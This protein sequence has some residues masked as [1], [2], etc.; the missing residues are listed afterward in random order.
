ME[1]TS[2]FALYDDI[3]VDE[4]CPA[5]FFFRE[6]CSP[7]FG[8]ARLVVPSQIGESLASWG[9]HLDSEKKIPCAL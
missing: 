2:L 4:Y 7:H 1:M 6:G 8:D 9:E 5:Y 3:C